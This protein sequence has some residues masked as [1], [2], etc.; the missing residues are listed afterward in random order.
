MNNVNEVPAVLKQK[1]YERVTDL[2][3]VVT[4]TV[5]VGAEY[6][7]ITAEGADVRWTD[8]GST[9]PTTSVGH[10]IDVSVPTPGIFYRHGKLSNLRFLE[11]GTAAVLNVSYYAK[12]GN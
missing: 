10:L 8:D 12:P 5:P 3:S 6:A 9:D 4:L 1:G 2:S 7:Y 11:T